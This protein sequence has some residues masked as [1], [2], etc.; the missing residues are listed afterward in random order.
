MSIDK[1]ETAYAKAQ[2]LEA[3]AD[4]GRE[5]D[6]LHALLRE[7]GMYTKAQVAAL[8]HQFMIQEVL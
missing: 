5:R 1:Q 6:M 8:L 3:K 7:D 4:S 2:W